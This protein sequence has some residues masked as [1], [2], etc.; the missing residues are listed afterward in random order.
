MPGAFPGISLQKSARIAACAFLAAT[1]SIT[2]S[3]RH[4]CADEAGRLSAQDLTAIVRSPSTHAKTT[5]ATVVGTG[6]L[7]T[8]LADK[9]QATSDS[10]MKIDAVFLAKALIDGSAGQVQSVKVLFSTPDRK[11]RFTM[12]DKTTV[13]N[14]GSGKLSP[15][16]LLATLVLVE[17]EPETGP[18][19]ADGPCMERR[20]LVWKRIE[21][22]KQQGT[23]VAPFQQLFQQI[24]TSLKT[25]DSATI[26][27]KLDFLESKLKEQ[28]EQVKLA[29]KAQQGHGV[30]ASQRVEYQPMTVPTLP[31]Q[32]MAG[33]QPPQG[34]QGQ[35]QQG[36]QGQ[37]QTAQNRGPSLWGQGGNSG[38]G[39]FPPPPPPG[40]FPPPP[41]P[42]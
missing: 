16:K 30:P 31:P 14:Y 25:A 38:Q 8:V 13:D 32:G 1:L 27:Q 4:S 40:G 7:V 15:E 6:P 11:P 42:Q 23:G 26:Q 5:D 21:R 29:K 28:E 39:G 24:E 22:L 35:G 41:P 12:V 2:I 9:A 3:C 10:D 37:G 19:V 17:V 36:P 33:G 18:Q 20:L 34:P